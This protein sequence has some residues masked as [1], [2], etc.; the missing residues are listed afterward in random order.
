MNNSFNQHLLTTHNHLQY[1]YF[2]QLEDAKTSDQRATI[3][4][5]LQE[6][7]TDYDK[8]DGTMKERLEMAS[9]TGFHG[10]R[11]ILDRTHQLCLNT[12]TWLDPSKFGESLKI[13]FHIN[14][15]M[16]SYTISCELLFF[17][18]MCS[19]MNFVIHWSNCVFFQLSWRQSQMMSWN[20]QWSKI[21]SVK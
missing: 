20:L 1:K 5:L 8:Q 4:Y 16:T 19:A 9:N 6:M 10:S 13:D 17:S 11:F 18:K 7:C 14:N 12:M 21:K 3:P 15:I 2:F